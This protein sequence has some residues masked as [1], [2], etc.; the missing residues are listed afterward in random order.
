MRCREERGKCEK[1]WKEEKERTN[2][3]GS[4]RDEIS[5]RVAHGEDG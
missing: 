4:V 2:S 1:E 5:Q 3:D